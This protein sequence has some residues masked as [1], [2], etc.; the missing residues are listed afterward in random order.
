MKIVN[1]NQLIEFMTG[2]LI[3]LKNG[4][5]T[6][7]EANAVANVSEKII[8]SVQTEISYNELKGKD[9][10]I[11]FMEK[12]PE[13]LA[14]LSSSPI[15]KLELTP[16]PEN[17]LKAEGVHTIGGLLLLSENDLL[18]TPNLGKRSLKEI[19]SALKERGLYLR[20]K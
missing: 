13:K 4:E 15:E 5:I 3:R 6:P 19:K 14:L 9:F 11:E 2:E 18:K 16:R 8:A 12:E 7:E 17:C 10:I 20:A 1:M